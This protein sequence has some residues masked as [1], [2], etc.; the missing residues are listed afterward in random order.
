MA[1][2]AI[3]P[4]PENA[5][6]AE[7]ETASRCAASRRAHLRI[8]A[9]IALLHGL[10]RT[11]AAKIFGSTPRT[12][13]RWI[14]AFNERGIDG[15][16]DAPRSGRPPIIP[17]EKKPVLHEVL[18]HPETVQ[19]THWTGVTFHGYLRRELELEIG[20]STV[21]RFLHEQG[22]ALKVPQP[23]PDRQDETLRQ[24]FRDK[25][26]ELLQDPTVD[27]WFADESGF[28]GD[29]RPRRRWAMKGHKARVT[30]NGDHVRMNVTG[31]VCSRT[32]QFYALEF[33]H[34]D[35]DIFQAFL[36]SASRD[37]KRERPRNILIVDNAS[38]HKAKRLD[39]GAFEPLF[40]PPY[41]PDLNPIERLW[42]LIKAHWFTDFIAKSHDELI[43]RL[44]LALNWVIQ[45]H[46]QNQ[47]TCAIRT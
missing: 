18:Q 8:R 34:S 26:K 31:M 7:L 37:V 43:R 17:A 24:K 40:L 13:L 22:F 41:S 1:R 25:I 12:L 14:R 15:L 28:E 11:L 10:D 45:R 19:Q 36:N 29:P 30:K 6:L 4:N 39:W 46:N 3:Q 2:Q 20:Y 27:L 32:G 47:K 5:S 23:W 35:T 16:L 21:I 38:W 44:D 42:L 33:T 9:I